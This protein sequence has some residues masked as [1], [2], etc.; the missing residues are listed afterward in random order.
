MS[1]EDFYR[2]LTPFTSFN[3]FTNDQH[4]KKVP[5]DWVVILSDIRGSTEA[6]ENGKYREVNTIGAATI[7]V[8]RKAMEGVDFPFV[9]GGDGATLLVPQ[10]AQVRVSNALIALKNLAQKNYDLELRVGVVSV[11]ELEQRGESVEAAK[12]EITSGKSIAL[13][14]GAGVTSAE[15]LIKETNRY[16]LTGQTS[17]EPDLSALSCRWNPIPSKKGKILTVLMSSRKDSKVY[18]QF[19]NRVDSIIPEGIESSNPTN[20]D[21]ASYKSIGQMLSEEKKLHSNSFSLSYF[22]RALEI[23]FAFLVFK[24]RF[25]AIF[26]DANKYSK[27]MRTHSDFRKFDD[28]LRMVLDCSMEEISKIKAYLMKSHEQGDLFYGIF[29]T[30]CSLMTCIVDG[31]GQG[32]HIHFI[33]AENGGYAAAAIQLKKQMKEEGKG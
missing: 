21:L 8:A 10:N 27:S 30:D 31:L 3:E 20:I 19:F 24:W 5:S 16:E 18:D 28:M 9:F 6:I 17:Q 26:F 23:C 11:Y 2:D 29:E 32:E 22:L 4:F 1:T 13:L 33:D 25:P 12:F 7:V 15:K 14:R